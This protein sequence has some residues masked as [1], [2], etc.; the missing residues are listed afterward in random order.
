MYFHYICYR[1]NLEFW[2][3]LEVQEIGGNIVHVGAISSLNSKIEFH[4]LGT[5]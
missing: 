4:C 2:I 5:I 1:A 3:E